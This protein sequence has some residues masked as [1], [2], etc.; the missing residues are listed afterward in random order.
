MGKHKKQERKEKSKVKLKAKKLPKGQ[1]ITDTSFKV[2]K[3]VIREQLQAPN[4]DD[5][6]SRRKLNIK[7]LL[8]H[9][10]HHN[11]SFRMDGLNGLKEIVTYHKDEVLKLHLP[12]LVEGVSRL[13]LDQEKDVRRNALKLLQSLLSSVSVLQIQP[14]LD[15]LQSYMACAMTHI[16]PS[17]QDDSLLLLDILLESCPLLIAAHAN[18][19]F[20]NFLDMISKLRSESKVGRTL[21]V[22]LGKKV[23]S[24]RWRIKVLSRLNGL[25]KAIMADKMKKAGASEEEI[26]KSVPWTKHIPLYN[27]GFIKL[28]PL[29]RILQKTSAVTSADVDEGQAMKTHIRLLMPLLFETWLEIA[30]RQEDREANI[31]PEESAVLLHCILKIV[32]LSWECLNYYEA[33]TRIKNLTPWFRSQCEQD[34]QRYILPGFPYTLADTPSTPLAKKLKLQQKQELELLLQNRS[35]VGPKCIQQNLAVCYLICCVHD[36]SDSTMCQLVT[37]YIKRC[38]SSWELADDPALPDLEQTLRQLLLKST[39]LWWHECAVVLECIVSVHRRSSNNLAQLLFSVLCDVVL[40]PSLQ[41]HHRCTKFRDWLGSLPNILCDAAVSLKTV[42]TMARLACQNNQLFLENLHRKAT[43][44]ISNLN[45]IRITGSTNP[46]EG[47]KLIV[48]ILFWASMQNAVCYQLLKQIVEK[49]QWAKELSQHVQ[50]N[51]ALGECLFS[52]T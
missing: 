22:D 11:M 45:N 39:Q 4:T 15:V 6:L 44:I 26:S 17:I 35:P 16:K 30:P 37:K 24:V 1:N 21:T 42:Q 40:E 25:L 38:V 29:P 33:E 50:N 46:L 10:Q 12:Q 49:G 47:Q 32:Q 18:K 36:G 9:L 41:Y 19:I 3:I 8:T 5:L 20:P 13:V 48:N 14:L 52:C 7:E 34:L 2:K 23:T 31:L 43:S 27:T 28:C 51:K